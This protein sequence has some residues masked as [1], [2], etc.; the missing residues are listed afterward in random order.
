MANEKGPDILGICETFLD[1]NVPDSQISID[2]FEF[3]RK[4]RSDVQNKT[5]GGV[6]L[7]FRKSLNCKRRPE[8]EISNIETIWAEVTLPNAKPFLVCSVYRPPNAPSDWIDLFEEELSIA[9]TTG[10]ELI[11]MGDFNINFISC[12]NRKWLHLMELFDL[13]QLVSDPTRITQASSS[14]IDHVYTSNTENITECF[15]PYFSISDHFPVCFTRK[16]NC[17]VSK[18]EH[19]TTTFRC[20]KQFDE[21]LFL[22]D[23]SNDLDTFK[24]GQCSIEEDFESL[25]T[26]ILQQLDKHAPI[27]TKRVKTKRLPDWFTPEISQAQELR[28]NS[29]RLQ[30]WADYKRYRNKTKQLIQQAKRKHFTESVKTLTDSKTIWKHLRN[31]NNKGNASH[32]NLP[33][34]LIINNDHITSSINIATKLNEYFSS[35]ADIFTENDDDFPALDLEKLRNFTNNNIPYDTFFDIPLITTDQVQ[36]FIQ[37]LDSSK[38]TGIDGIGPRIIKLAVNCLSPTIAIL[39]NKSLIT[40]QFP[41]QLKLAKVFPIYK[42]GTK[43]DP[44]NYRPISILPTISKIFEKHIN[45][46]LMGFLNKYKLIHENQSGFRQKHSCQTA[47]V[48]LID[49]WMDCIDKGDM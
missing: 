1:K 39:I 6:I 43:L 34:E 30:K 13:S 9:Q 22:T 38:A 15:V 49:S 24:V 47:L 41:A 5:G 27:R 26:I 14:I 44:S 32:N 20:F 7:F 45:S 16:I 12:T 2:G 11:L 33:E 10:F 8:L 48:K 31:V 4:D 46:H 17:K 18:S 25:Y 40:G 21:T 3:I 36:S 35:I 23:L 19:I 29:K 37:N 42:G 28:D